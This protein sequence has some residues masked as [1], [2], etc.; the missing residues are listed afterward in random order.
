MSPPETTDT[1]LQEPEQL[2]EPKKV[3]SV[4]ISNDTNWPAERRLITMRLL[5]VSVRLKNSCWQEASQAGRVEA[6][7]H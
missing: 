7:L 2:G 3:V 1:S 4:V 5:L 6:A